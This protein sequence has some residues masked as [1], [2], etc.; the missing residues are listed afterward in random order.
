M[1][2]R[3]F[4]AVAND[5]LKEDVKSI[6]FSKVLPLVKE[7]NHV[8]GLKVYGESTNNGYAGFMMCNEEGFAI[9]KVFFHDDAF[10]YHAPYQQKSR[11]S[12]NFDRQTFRSKKLSTL[13]STLKK[14]NIVT[15]TDRVLTHYKRQFDN[16]VNK[17]SNSFEDKSKEGISAPFAQK[18]LQAMVEGKDI[19]SFQ[20]SDRDFYLDVLDKYKNIDKMKVVKKEGI[21]S[22]FK[23]CHLVLADGGGQYLV[24]ESTYEYATN[25]NY[26]GTRLQ[27][28]PTTPFKRVKNLTD[29]PSVISTMTMLKVHLGDDFRSYAGGTNSSMFPLGDKHIPDLEVVYGY[30]SRHGDF[31]MGYL[32]LSK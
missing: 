29:Y 11:G 25:T 30:E 16:L 26:H 13:M 20:Q 27:I 19:N 23:D 18:L 24:S 10:C 15:T 8:Y 12:D 6:I 22:M 1:S 9:A 14:A 17:V 5:S 28:K 31:D 7:L 32:C 21:E 4:H 2:D 3:L